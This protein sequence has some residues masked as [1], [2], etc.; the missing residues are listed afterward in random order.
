MKRQAGQVGKSARSSKSFLY[1]SK[2]LSRNPHDPAVSLKQFILLTKGNHNKT[3]NLT[4][5]KAIPLRY[6]MYSYSQE[7]KCFWN[8][9]N[10]ARPCRSEPS[11][12][13]TVLTTAVCSVTGSG[14]KLC[15]PH[16]TTLRGSGCPWIFAADKKY[17]QTRIAD[18]AADTENFDEFEYSS[19]NKTASAVACT[20]SMITTDIKCKYRR[21]KIQSTEIFDLLA[22]CCQQQ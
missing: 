4:L 14:I 7:R 17:I 11:I 19:D 10:F 12:D 21:N 18:K 2:T 8:S 3:Q 15:D 5:T 13:R 9:Y 16:S 1:I 20:M 22:W 6:T